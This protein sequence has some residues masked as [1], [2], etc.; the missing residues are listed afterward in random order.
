MTDLR[1]AVGSRLPARGEQAA[2]ADASMRELELIRKE[3]EAQ[4]T[5]LTA[6]SAALTA[7][8]ALLT[9]IES[10]TDIV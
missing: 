1:A 5:L 6:I 8:T 9:D 2:Q 4:R 10:N 3:L 7:H